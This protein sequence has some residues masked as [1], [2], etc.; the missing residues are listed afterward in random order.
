MGKYICC[1]CVFI[2]DNFV[3]YI[4]YILNCQGTSMFSRILN[5]FSSGIHEQNVSDSDKEIHY[6][7]LWIINNK[8]RNQ[9]TVI[10]PRNH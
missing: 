2:Y 10:K 9:V 4:F 8:C 7:R 3:I 1:Y 5:L 6:L